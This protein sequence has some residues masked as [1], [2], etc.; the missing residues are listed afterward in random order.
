MAMPNSDV[1]RK[2]WLDLSS[3]ARELFRTLYETQ[4]GVPS[5]KLQEKL[6]T[7]DDG[8]NSII[9]WMGRS[10]EKG[11]GPPSYNFGAECISWDYSNYSLSPR[12][13]PVVG[14]LLGHHEKG[15]TILLES[16]WQIAGMAKSLENRSGE[17]PGDIP[18]DLAMEFKSCQ[19]ELERLSQDLLK[20]L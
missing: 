19:Q 16:L 13:R 7:N 2:H 8:I 6:S 14:E 4:D 20:L 5:Q 3:N 17:I 9:G 12:V 11:G 10:I 1:L 15:K 18:A